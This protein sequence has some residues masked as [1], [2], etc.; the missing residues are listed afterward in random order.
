[1]VDWEA[2]LRKLGV[3]AAD[4]GSPAEDAM[5]VALD[6]TKRKRRRKMK[7]HKYVHVQYANHSALTTILLG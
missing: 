4:G 6:S 5:D 3:S 2:A 1:M 7:K